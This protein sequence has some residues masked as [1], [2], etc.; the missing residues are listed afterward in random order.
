MVKPAG[1]LSFGFKLIV[2]FAGVK[3][4]GFVIEGIKAAV[5]TSHVVLLIDVLCPIFTVAVYVW[6]VP[7]PVVPL[8]CKVVPDPDTTGAIDRVSPEEG[9]LT[10]A[11]PPILACK[12]VNVLEAS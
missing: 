6:L 1:E 11:P 4:E 7:E 12:E 3:I 2:P 9:I 8:I 5:A 10:Q